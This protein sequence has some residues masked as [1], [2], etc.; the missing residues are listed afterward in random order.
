MGSIVLK[1]CTSSQTV[2]QTST[3]PS[4]ASSQAAG[5]EDEATLYEAAKKEG[6]VV[7]YTPLTTQEILGEVGKAFTAKYPGIDFEG[8]RLSSQV[9][10]QKVNQELQAGLRI[11]DVVVSGDIS[12]SMKLKE[13]GQFIQYTPA[14]KER[15]MAQYRNLDPDNYYHLAGFVPIVLA[16]NTQKMTAAEAPKSWK[17]L[18]QDKYKDKIS[19]GSPAVSGVLGVW[20]LSMQQKYGWDEYMVKFSQLNP[21]LGRSLADVVPVI[22]TGDRS[23]AIAPLPITLDRKAKGDPIEIIYPTDGTIMPP[24]TGGILKT[25]AH[26]NAAKLLMNFLGSK[27]YW[28]LVG[29]YYEYP[30]RDDGSLKGLQ[31]LDAVQ[32]YTPKSEDI[33]DQAPEII[34]KWRD[35]FGV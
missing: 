28:D 21:L 18:L 31:S 1:G 5:V 10:F 11:V 33:R 19:T 24:C 35:L 27:E 32:A 16:Y 34:K 20:A 7:M 26:P 6:K 8:T 29:E 25:A 2:S 17:D 13:Q 14:N 12:H 4:G 9:L 3:S 22:A 30:I 15:V 23:I